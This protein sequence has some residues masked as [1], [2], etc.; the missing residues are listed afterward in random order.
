MNALPLMK[1]IRAQLIT[2]ERKPAEYA[3]GDVQQVL[4]DGA[5]LYY[6]SPIRD[7]ERI[8]PAL[9]Y[10]QNTRSAYSAPVWVPSEAPYAANLSL[11]HPGGL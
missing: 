7:L 6:W 10:K 5:A 1:R 3:D 8:S 11:P 2:L 9:T 4:G